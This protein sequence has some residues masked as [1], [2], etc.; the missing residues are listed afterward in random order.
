MA[1]AKCWAPALSDA[2]KLSWGLWGRVR[3]QMLSPTSQ[4]PAQ[5][6]GPYPPQTHS[7]KQENVKNFLPVPLTSHLWHHHCPIWIQKPP[8][9]HICRVFH[10]LFCS[11]F[12]TT[13]K[14]HKQENSGRKGSRL[15]HG[16][17]LIWIQI[18]FSLFLNLIIAFKCIKLHVKIVHRA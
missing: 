14:T 18:S 7:L 1:S 2:P 6:K 10:C 5:L 13:T 3:S 16:F 11:F 4:A 9:K 8:L 12:K 17:Y 15:R